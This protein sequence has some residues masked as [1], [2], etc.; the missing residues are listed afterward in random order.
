MLCLSSLRVLLPDQVFSEL[1]NRGVED[2]LML[3]PRRAE[4]AAGRGRD[5]LASRGRP[6]VHRSLDSQQHPVLRPPG[7]KKCRQALKPVYTAL[8]EAATTE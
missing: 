1:K 3:V 8:S 5:G 6:N 4:G 7:L 2:V